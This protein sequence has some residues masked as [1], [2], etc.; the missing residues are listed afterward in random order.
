MSEAQRVENT[1]TRRDVIKASEWYTSKLV[2]DA[3]V[4]FVAAE[5]GV[6]LWLVLQWW[7]LLLL[8][9]QGVMRA[10]TFAG[11]G[12]LIDRVVHSAM[13]PSGPQLR[14]PGL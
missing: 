12:I 5:T 11:S 14:R 10:G 1:Y 4:K 3:H 9:G 2:D 6:V 13:E 7:L 8:L